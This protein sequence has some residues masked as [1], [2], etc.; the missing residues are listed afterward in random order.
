MIQT[1]TASRFRSSPTLDLKQLDELPPEQQAAFRE[2]QSDSDFYGL[3]VPRV[4]GAASIKSVGQQTAHL[5]SSLATPSRLFELDDPAYRED[6]IDLVL[7]GILEIEIGGAFCGGADAF[8]IVA[9]QLP[10]AIERGRI[11]TLSR[12][13]LQHA[14]DLATRDTALLAS[15]LY[16]YNRIPRTRAWNAR[17]PD[18]AGVLRAI[19]AEDTLKRHWIRSENPP[20]WIAWRSIHPVPQP[21]SPITHKL[22]VSPLPEHVA[23][24]FQALVRVLAEIPGTQM[25]IGMDAAGLLRPDKIVAYFGSREDLDAAARALA[26]E[27][28][29]CPAHGVPFTAGFLGSSGP[30]GEGTEDPRTREPEEPAFHDG[31][32]SW[33][34]DPPDSE[35]PLSWLDRESW[36][37]WIAKSLATALALAKGAQKPPAERVVEPWRFAVE[38]VRRHGVDVDTWTP[39][40]TLWRS[41]A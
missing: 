27:L 38:R 33:G 24:A 36:R 20:A 19:G 21:R 29:G 6:I 23:D 32:L 14:E 35:R 26:G 25:K 34:I 37:L 13:A 9:S 8:R 18:A 10:D 7:D 17:F 11:A 22:Y 15:A 30:R 5:F 39:S 3:L 41:V 1:W 2:L 12:E 28:K 40:D 31:L 4:A 16:S